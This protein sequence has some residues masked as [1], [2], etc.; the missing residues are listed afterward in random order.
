MVVVPGHSCH[1]FRRRW[2]A[3]AAVVVAA[4]GHCWV[5]P[6]S[7]AGRNDDAKALVDNRSHSENGANQSPEKGVYDE[8]KV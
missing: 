8:W 2:A 5:N 6:G 4:C 1:Y 7:P 3:A